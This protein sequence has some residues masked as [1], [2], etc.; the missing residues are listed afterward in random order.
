MSVEERLGEQVLSLTRELQESRAEVAAAKAAGWD[1][2]AAEAELQRQLEEQ[3]AAEREKR[4]EHTKEMAVRRIGKRD[5]TRG[6]MAW[7]EQYLEQAR[8]KR[9]LLAAGSKLLRPKLVACYTQWR[10]MYEEEKAAKASMSMSD[11]LTAEVKERQLVQA[12]L[13]QLTRDLAEARQ[14]ALEGR[15]QE[16]ELQR[17]ME[18]RLEREKEKRI[19]HTQEMA[20]KRI[21]KRDL[22]RGWQGWAEPYLEKKRLERALKA[23]GARMLKPKLMAAFTK[24]RRDW[25]DEKHAKA[26]MSLEERLGEQLLTVTK[27]LEEANRKLRD[28]QG[29]ESDWQRQLEERL[30]LEKEKRIEHTKEMAMRRIGKR[31]LT[32]GWMAWL[33]QYLEQARLKRALLAAGSKLL[34]PKLVACYTQWRR[35]YEEEKA[36]KASMSMSDKLTAEVKER[37]LV[38]AQLDQLTRDLAEARQAALEGRGQEAELQRQMEERLEREKEKRIAHTQEMALKRIGKRDLARGWQGWAEPYLEKKRLERALKAA[39]ARMLK[40]K[41]MAAFTKW[42]RDWE[43]EQQKYVGSTQSWHASS[44]PHALVA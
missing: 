2:A 42:R 1:G 35:M 30:A 4:I 24:W 11:K 44:L 19:A 39:G 34:R 17:Q 38:Q 16:A 22:A 29:A 27:Q 10:R 13:D 6:W 28:G 21:G 18:E 33:E 3:L 5:L 8:L 36:A 40:P 41:L 43:I 32:R 14:A 25:E 7:L 23:A 12:Q 15:G 37:Q 20:L 31:D 26:A 9:A